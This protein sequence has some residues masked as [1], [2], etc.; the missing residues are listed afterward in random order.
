MSPEEVGRY[1]R[2]HIP[3]SAGMDIRVLEEGDDRVVIEAPL[4]PNLNHRA[5][6]FGGS[7]AALAI[8]TG[9]TLV[10]FRLR[11]AGFETHTVIQQSRVRYDAPIE[12]PFRAVAERVPDEVWDRLTKMLERRG[13]GRVELTARV[14]SE[15]GVV[16]HF[17]G[18]YVALAR[19]DT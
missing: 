2:D 6:A 17:R 14:E 15:G 10:H 7:V 19:S 9:W 12:G 8:I 16:G 18:S 5:T 4:G 13:K 11:R 1:L 3:L